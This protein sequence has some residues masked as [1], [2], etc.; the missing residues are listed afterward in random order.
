[1][2]TADT[3]QTGGSRKIY[4]NGSDT[5]LRVPMREIALTNG[6]RHYVYDTG[7]PYT[8]PALVT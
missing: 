6:E 2:I 5:S 7:G 4:V 3:K 8:D 1:M